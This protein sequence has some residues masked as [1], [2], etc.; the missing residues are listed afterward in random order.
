MD[1]PKT[2]VTDMCV[3]RGT[4]HKWNHGWQTGFSSL[5]ASNIAGWLRL[6]IRDGRGEYLR[7]HKYTTRSMRQVRAE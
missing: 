5:G 3:R 1:A 4:Y 7:T 6:L 2:G